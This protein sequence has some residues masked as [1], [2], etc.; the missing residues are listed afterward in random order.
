MS[1][2]NIVN[3]AKATGA[4]KSMMDAVQAKI[5]MT[6]NFIR[7][8][9]NS[10]QALEAYLGFSG[11]LAKGL[12]DAK[13]QERIAL[14]VS[15][16]N[17]CSYCVSAHTAIGQGAGLDSAEMNAARR[18]SS[19]DTKAAAIVAFARALNSNRGEVTS[20]EIDAVRKAGCNDGEIVEIISQVAL[21]SLTNLLAK[22][23]RVEIDFPAV[24][25]MAKTK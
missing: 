12:L 10:P 8:F 11:S 6:P 22:A 23:S 15:E 19:T 9:A 18:G 7:L 21:H 24:E 14:G 2:I 1:R 13:T 17:S 25:L 20:A 3:P 4:A 5:G 16:A